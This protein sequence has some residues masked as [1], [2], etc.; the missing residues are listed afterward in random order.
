MALLW[1]WLGAVSGLILA[2]W[3]A[4]T[5]GRLKGLEEAA[6]VFKR[7]TEGIVAREKELLEVLQGVLDKA[8]PDVGGR[9]ASRQQ[10]CGPAC[11]TYWIG[12][13]GA[14]GSRQWCQTHQ[15]EWAPEPGCARGT[16]G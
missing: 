11:R 16:S 15:R 10:A 9:T 13:T 4:A 14:P 3:I 7:T 12:S 2:C 6:G 1:V 8:P 5:E